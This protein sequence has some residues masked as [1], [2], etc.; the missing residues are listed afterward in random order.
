MAAKTPRVHEEPL[1]FEGVL[2]KLAG[3]MGRYVMVATGPADDAPAAR[4]GSRPLQASGRLQA[5]I[6]GQ[7]EISRRRAPGRDVFICSLD[8]GATLAISERRLTG[9]VFQR[10]PDD[11]NEIL[12]LTLGALRMTIEDLDA[13]QE[14]QQRGR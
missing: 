4:G 14:H 11:G 7:A 5:A 6:D 10:W 8:S 12:V 9:A 1:D 13:L 3:M 2:V